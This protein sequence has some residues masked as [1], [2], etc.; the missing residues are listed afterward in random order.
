KLKPDT[1]PRLRK[2][3]A[4]WRDWVMNDTELGSAERVALW[5]MADNGTKSKTARRYE[6]IKRIYIYPSQAGI[7]AQSGVSLNTVKRAIQSAVEKGYLQRNSRGSK[8]GG[9]S[10]YRMMMPPKK[11][12]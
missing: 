4:R 12:S 7:A 6:E 2:R 1:L 9:T 10:E 8:L 3:K 11:S 5:H